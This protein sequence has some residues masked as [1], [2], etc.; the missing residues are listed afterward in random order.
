MAAAGVGGK[1]TRGLVVG[2]ITYRFG[3]GVLQETRECYQ[4]C[5]CDT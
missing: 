5:G 2:G 3:C 1:P 4:N